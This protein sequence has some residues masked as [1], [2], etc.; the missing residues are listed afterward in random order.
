M[1]TRSKTGAGQ[2]QAPPEGVLEGPVSQPPTDTEENRGLAT[3]LGDGE[4]P[5]VGGDRP[6]VRATTSTSGNIQVVSEWVPT[7]E[8][9]TKHTSP[10]PTTPTLVLA[11]SAAA[12]IPTLISSGTGAP[13]GLEDWPPSPPEFDETKLIDRDYCDY[14]DYDYYHDENVN[15]FDDKN[16]VCHPMYGD[17]RGPSAIHPPVSSPVMPDVFG[18]PR[19]F[20]PIS[21]GHGRMFQDSSRSRDS[22]RRSRSSSRATSRASGANFDWVGDFARKFADDAKSREQRDADERKRLIGETRQRESKAF[23]QVTSQ[24]KSSLDFMQD[25]IR[26]QN[27]LAI[28]RERQIQLALQRE[29]RN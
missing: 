18:R 23:E 9:V 20:C 2:L 26:K 27:D 3:L 10:Q 22:R 25:L 17:R 28:Q 5:T 8:P 16:A 24:G 4:V 21:R 14:D 19:A 15:P 1:E 13:E 7:R 29:K 11:E 12:R 6:E